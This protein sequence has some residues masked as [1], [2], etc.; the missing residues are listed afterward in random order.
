MFELI[1]GALNPVPLP[2]ERGV[3]GPGR[4]AAGPGWNHRRGPLAL[5]VLNEFLT[6]IAFVGD[7]VTSAEAGEQRP[8][9]RTV[10]PLPSGDNKAHGPPVAIRGEM[11]LGG[12]SA[13]GPPHSRLRVPPFPVTAC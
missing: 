11:N 2:V 6:V 10:V 3:I 5:N 1:E 8:G 9:L 7:D 13:S 12:Q 4:P